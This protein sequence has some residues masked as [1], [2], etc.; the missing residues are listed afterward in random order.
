M[1]EKE[2]KGHHYICGVCGLHISWP[3]YVTFL[4]EAHTCLP[5]GTVR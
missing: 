5:L 3:E 1:G 4:L 2:L